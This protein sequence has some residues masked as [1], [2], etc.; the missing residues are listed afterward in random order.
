MTARSKS[1]AV[2]LKNGS[3]LVSGGLNGPL[4]TSELVTGDDTRTHGMELPNG[5]YGH[6]MLLLISGQ[7]FLHGGKTVSGPV[8][9]T[10]IS[11]ESVNWEQ[12]MSSKNSRYNHAC[13]EV[14]INLDQQ[15]WVGGSYRDETTEIFEPSN[16]IWIEGPSLPN[17]FRYPGEFVSNLGK[18]YYI[19]GWGNMNIFKLMDGWTKQDGWEKE[20]C[21]CSFSNVYIS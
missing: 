20:S 9:D 19:G 16:N 15:V 4:K 1:S 18:V 21:L 8:A 14:I 13:T 17:F 11:D 5:L 12:M 6:C 2:L 3:V 7:I 10:Y